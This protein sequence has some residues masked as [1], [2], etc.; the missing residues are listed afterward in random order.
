MRQGNARRQF[1]MC[2]RSKSTVRLMV[3]VGTGEH[4]MNRP[5]KQAVSTLGHCSV[6]KT[7]FPCATASCATH[8]AVGPFCSRRPSPPPRSARAG[9][10]V[11]RAVEQQHLVRLAPIA[12][13]PRM[14][15]PTVRSCTRKHPGPSTSPGAPCSQAADK[16]PASVLAPQ[17]A[18]LD[19]RRPAAAPSGTIAAPATAPRSNRA[20]APCTSSATTCHAVACSECRVLG[21]R[22]GL[23]RAT[24][25]SGSF[26]STVQP[27]AALYYGILRSDSMPYA[28]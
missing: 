8:H 27:S 28:L 1:G 19:P 6:G 7:G 4:R 3:P 23:A 16:R 17:L 22:S 21:A 25:R 12:G 10:F 24:T 14:R 15:F 2:D 11:A 9:G 26:M 13:K 5:T 20:T 18:V